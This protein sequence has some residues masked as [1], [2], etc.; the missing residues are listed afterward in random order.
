MSCAPILDTSTIKVGGIKFI[1]KVRP[2]EFHTH[3]S[4]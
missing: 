3:T 2:I 4:K 1:Q